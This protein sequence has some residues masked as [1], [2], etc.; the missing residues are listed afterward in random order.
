MSRPPRRA[1]AEL[2]IFDARGRSGDDNYFIAPNRL[3]NEF[4]GRAGWAPAMVASLAAGAGAAAATDAGVSATDGLSAGAAGLAAACFGSTCFGAA[5]RERATDGGES[6]LSDFGFAAAAGGALAVVSEPPMPTL[7]ARLE[8]QPSDCCAGCCV[9][10]AAATRVAGADVD[11]DQPVVFAV[12]DRSL[13][14]VVSDVAGDR[15]R[16]PRD[17]PAPHAAAL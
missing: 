10:V 2:V 15:R 9:G 8:N 6:L 7:R 1:S 4:D 17:P 11:P 16:H 5:A 12:P 3:S 14:Q 13:C